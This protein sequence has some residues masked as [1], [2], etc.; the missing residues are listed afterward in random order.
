MQIMPQCEMGVLHDAPPSACVL[1]FKLFAQAFSPLVGA[2][3][4]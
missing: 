1:C 2:A 4:M 3:A